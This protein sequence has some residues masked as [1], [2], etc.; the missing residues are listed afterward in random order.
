[1]RVILI[2]MILGML[3][4]CKPDKVHNLK[5]GDYDEH[6]RLFIG[7][8]APGESKDIVITLGKP[9]RLKE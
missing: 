3:V 8:L 6:G 7:D 4:S 5:P 1:M 2:I 9:P